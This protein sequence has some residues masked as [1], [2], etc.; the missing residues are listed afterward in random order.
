MAVAPAITDF[1]RATAD[2]TR[3]TDLLLLP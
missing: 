3:A 2:I 1:T